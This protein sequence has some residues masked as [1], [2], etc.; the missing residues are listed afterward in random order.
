MQKAAAEFAKKNGG[1]RP[2]CKLH[3]G[4]MGNGHGCKFGANCCFYHPRKAKGSLATTGFRRW[5]QLPDFN[6]FREGEELVPIG[7]HPN[8]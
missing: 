6:S 2:A 7:A 4:Q 3:S 5:N 8:Y 1:K